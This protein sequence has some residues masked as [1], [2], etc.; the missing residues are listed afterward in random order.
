MV[1]LAFLKLLKCCLIKDTLA[2][3]SLLHCFVNDFKKSDILGSHL[4]NLKQ[5]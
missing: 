5:T 2:V 3:V 1:H 4:Q